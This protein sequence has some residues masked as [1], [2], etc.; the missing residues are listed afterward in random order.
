MDASLSFTADGI[1]GKVGVMPL[2]ERGCMRIGIALGNYLAES[3]L[4]LQVIMGMDTRPSS[5]KIFRW[6]K[7]GLLLRDVSTYDL[8]V[9]TT[10]GLAYHVR[11]SEVVSLG[12]MITAS[13][14]PVEF[15][16][17]KLLGDRGQRLTD[18]AIHK[19]Q[20]HFQYTYIDQ[21]PILGIENVRKHSFS[22]KA[23]IQE[24]IKLTG[25]GSLDGIKLAVDCSNG[26]ASHVIPDALAQLGAIVIP[27]NQYSE[28]KLINH[29]CGTEYVRYFPKKF[30]ERIQRMAVDYGIV[31]DGD[32]DR[33]V[34]VDKL[35]G[36]YNGDD[37]LFVLA[38]ILEQQGLFKKKCVVTSHMANSGLSQA[39][40]MM[41]I[42]LIRTKNGDK[43]M[44][45]LLFEENYLLAG[46]QFG[47]IIIHDDRHISADPFYALLYILKEIHDRNVT[48]QDL[49]QSLR[50][51]PQFLMQI[52][53]R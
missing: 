43:H 36:F 33:L 17:V 21:H 52:S 38:T 53:N 20:K 15:N 9:I 16:G 29:R 45:K 25:I 5:T 37:M 48:I 46:E 1:R 47:N 22:F 26:S 3:N 50:K 40:D 7:D 4:P 28:G 10:P 23:Y 34:I 51:W 27:L 2:T 39:L 6:I 24:Q 14:N 30:A 18:D 11:N 42:K 49:T 35:G 19:I 44:E 13:H 32:A 8:G 12:I 31:F 41:G